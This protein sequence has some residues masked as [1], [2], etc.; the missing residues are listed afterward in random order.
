MLQ[1]NVKAEATYCIIIIIININYCYLFLFCS[2]LLSQAF[3]EPTVDYDSSD[4]I[5]WTL[6]FAN[7]GVAIKLLGF[8]FVRCFFFSH[9]NGHSCQ[10]I[11]S[12]MCKPFSC[13]K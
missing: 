9:Y 3:H 11:T 13:G 6:I 4:D 12:L 1:P 10:L 5:K 8:S 7:P 2:L